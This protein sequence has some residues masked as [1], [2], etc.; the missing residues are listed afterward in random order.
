MP[1][2][3]EVETVC[4][5]LRELIIDKKITFIDVFYDRIIQS[6]LNEF[7]TLLVNQTFR[8]IERKGKYIIFIL[9]NYIIV[10]QIC[11]C[12]IQRYFCKIAL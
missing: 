2:L 9:D 10:S 6:D 1:E 12:K 4:R 5:S 7:K 11:K 8:S 3:P